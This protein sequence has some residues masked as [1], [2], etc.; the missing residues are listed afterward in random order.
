MHFSPC[1]SVSFSSSSHAAGS[2]S[3]IVLLFLSLCT[4]SFVVV[5]FIVVCVRVR[6]E[7]CDMIHFFSSVLNFMPCSVFVFPVM[8]K[9]PLCNAAH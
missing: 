2:F 1:I 7:S 4:R 5:G 6:K 9:I 8:Q 3:V